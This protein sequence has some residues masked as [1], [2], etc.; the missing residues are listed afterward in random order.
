MLLSLLSFLFFLLLCLGGIGDFITPLLVVVADGLVEGLALF[1]GTS[2]GA[3]EGD[4]DD[5]EVS[6][7]RL[8]RISSRRDRVLPPDRRLVTD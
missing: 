2:N 6:A 8:C 7:S 4:E 3:L 5:L 1:E